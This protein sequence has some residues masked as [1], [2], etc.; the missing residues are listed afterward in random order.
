MDQAPFALAVNSVAADTYRAASTGRMVSGSV[1]PGDTCE[2]LARG[3]ADDLEPGESCPPKARPPAAGCFTIEVLSESLWTAY[4][5]AGDITVAGI[6]CDVGDTITVSQPSER[7]ASR[8]LVTPPLAPPT[9]S[10]VGP[11]TGPFQRGE[12]SDWGAIRIVSSKRSITLPLMLWWM[13]NVAG[14]WPW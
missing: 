10:T 5:R 6:D 2:T 1:R 9:L 12:Q 14:V 13:A 11:N 8:P 3:A 4:R 7:R